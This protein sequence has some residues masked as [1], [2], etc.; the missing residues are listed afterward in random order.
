MCCR[1]RIF[2]YYLGEIGFQGAKIFS[3][4]STL[5]FKHA[6]SFPVICFTMHR[7]VHTVIIY[8][9]NSVVDAE[10]IRIIDYF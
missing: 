3:Q 1:H 6:S 2:K 8:Q 9:T 10:L 7:P 5:F 4:F